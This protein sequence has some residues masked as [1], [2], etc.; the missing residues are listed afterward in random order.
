MTNEETAIKQ[1]LSKPRPES[2][3]CG[4][5]GPRNGEPFCSCAMQWCE[6]V[7]DIW[8]KITEERNSTGIE[9]KATR[10]DRI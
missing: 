6:T 2:F 9:L 10:V 3:G 4:C 5:V 7:N 8:Y 1:H